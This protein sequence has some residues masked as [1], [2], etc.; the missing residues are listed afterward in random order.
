METDKASFD[1]R[2]DKDVVD[3]H[4]GILLSHKKI[5]FATTWMDFG[6]IMLSKINWTEKVKNHVISLM[7]DVK[8]KAIYEQI[9]KNSQT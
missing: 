6:K 3:I 2:L 9:N 5:P 1:I 8:V 4:N 7:W